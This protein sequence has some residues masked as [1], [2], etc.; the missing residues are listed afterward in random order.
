MAA[1]LQARLEVGF[2]VVAN[3]T[4]THVALPWSAVTHGVLQSRHPDRL[5]ALSPNQAL[6]AATFARAPC[7]RVWEVATGAVVCDISCQDMTSVWDEEDDGLPFTGVC[8]SGDSQLLGVS[9]DLVEWGA[10]GGGAAFFAV[11]PSKTLVGHRPGHGEYGVQGLMAVGPRAFLLEPAGVW[12]DEHYDIPPDMQV[13]HQVL[14]VPY[15]RRMRQ[16]LLT[17]VLASRRRGGPRLPAELLAFLAGQ[18]LDPGCT[19]TW[20]NEHQDI[21]AEMADHGGVED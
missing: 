9:V 13:I 5:V 7:V 11:R 6:V 15:H 16:R 3:D 17:L 21:F 2:V 20:D 8:F 19:Q 12:W 4:G 1:M 10:M 18:F 14:Y